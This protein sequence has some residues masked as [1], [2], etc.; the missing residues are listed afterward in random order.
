MSKLQVLSF[1]FTLNCRGCP[2]PLKFMSF[3]F[4]VSISC[5]ICPFRLTQLICLV[6]LRHPGIF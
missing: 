4:N 2:L 3:V 6:K 1:K 5:T